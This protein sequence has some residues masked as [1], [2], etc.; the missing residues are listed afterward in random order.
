M[1]ANSI[2][3]VMSC[4]ECR[5]AFGR[6]RGVY[7]EQMKTTVVYTCIIHVTTLAISG[8]R[9]APFSELPGHSMRTMH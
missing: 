9:A 8:G 6:S 2:L 7:S 1:A 3:R 4:A 5:S